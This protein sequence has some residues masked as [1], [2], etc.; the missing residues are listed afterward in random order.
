MRHHQPNGVGGQAAAHSGK[1][2]RMVRKQV[3]VSFQVVVF[4]AIAVAFA[5]CKPKLGAKCKIDSEISCTSKTSALVCHDAKWTEMPCRGAKG[6]AAT[7]DA[8]T[9]DQTVAK[10]GDECEVPA[11]LA[12]ADDK[13]S[14]LECK[15]HKWVLDEACLGPKG[16]T[17]QNRELDCDT[18]TSKEGDKCA[19]EN[20]HACS[21]D[22]KSHLVCKGGK[23]ALVEHCRGAKACSTVGTKV[24]CD[25][26]LAQA[27][28]PCDTVNHHACS[29]DGKMVVKCDGTK[30][31]ADDPCKGKKICKLTGIDVGCQ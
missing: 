30:W 17:M 11:N 1:V 18:T 16:C 20:N 8:V 21:M 6:C 7:G 19:R 29:L 24:Q 4:A 2:Q 14:S 23:Y 15:D 9:C 5:G 31:L 25:D 28:E 26:S 12:C 13:K 22:Q 27:G 10:L 3:R